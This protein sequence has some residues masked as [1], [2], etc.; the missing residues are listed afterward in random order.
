V[1]AAVLPHSPICGAAVV[2]FPLHP[3]GMP[4]L[5]VG[6]VDRSRV[7]RSARHTG[8]MS[9]EVVE[10]IRGAL[11]APVTVLE[12]GDYECP[13]CAAA[14]PVLREL[15]EMSDGV[16]RL[17][18]RN[19][20]LFETHPHALTAALAVESTQLSGVFW[21]MHDLLFKRQHRLDDAA[22]RGYADAVGADPDLAVGEPAQRF[23]PKVRSDYAAGVRQGVRGTP[24]LFVNDE[25]YADRVELRALQRATGLSRSLRRRPWWRR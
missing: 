7:A 21:E 13:Y 25:P 22:L 6:R 10:H 17:V 20:P 12:Y 8:R 1:G 15:V 19:F 11:D 16:V 3:P 18:F 5:E 9:D 23:V 24:T 14:A 2:L 4:A